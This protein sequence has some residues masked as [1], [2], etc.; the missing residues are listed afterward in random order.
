MRELDGK[1]N[2]LESSPLLF[3]MRLILFF[4]FCPLLLFGQS[5]ETV[6]QKGHELAVVTVAISPDSNYIATG[7][8]DKSA[9]LWETSTG[10]EVRSFLGHQATVTSV[11][12]SSDAKTLVTG[13]ND[14]SIR[15]WEVASGRELYAIQ[16]DDI[17]TDIAIDPLMKFFVVAGYGNSGYGDSIT[18]YDFHTKSELKKI[19]ASPDKGLGSGVD[20]AISPNGIYL[21]V[22]EDNRTANL[23]NTDDW[24]IV[25]TF[26]FEEGW[27]GGCGTRVLFGPDSKSLYTATH[28]GPVRKYALDSFKLVRT[29]EEKMEN[30]KGFAISPDGN[31]LARATEKEI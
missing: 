26:P 9:K 29:Y 15:F 21:A 23:Y 2:F 22:G 16:T 7:S 28:N 18:V 30:L 17:I 12:F 25:K 27:C 24:S 31:T 3:T 4:I 10:R 8:K 13:S 14:K 6:V 5:L 20:V 1:V 11:E 19:P